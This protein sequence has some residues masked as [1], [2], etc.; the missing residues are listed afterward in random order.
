MEISGIG[1]TTGRSATAT[2]AGGIGP[3]GID[4]SAA[5]LT[6][7]AGAAITATVGDADP[8]VGTAGIVGT[9]AIGTTGS[10]GPTEIG[11]AGPTPIGTVDGFSGTI[12]TTDPTWFVGAG[13]MVRVGMRSGLLADGPAATAVPAT[14]TMSPA[15]TLARAGRRRA[16]DDRLVSSRF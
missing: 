9:P 4:G 2:V 8:V 16:P 7:G 14:S 11:D 5:P 1:P 15:S 12:G 3:M 10:A 13:G 6:G